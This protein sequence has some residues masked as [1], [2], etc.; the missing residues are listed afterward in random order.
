[1][2]ISKTH[3]EQ[4]PIEIVQ[5]ILDTQVR[6]GPTNEQD[7]ETRKKTLEEDLIE[8]RERTVAGSGAHSG[9]ES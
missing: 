7:Q 3:Y 1:M 6:D 9:R 4:V 5:K 8:G 2:L